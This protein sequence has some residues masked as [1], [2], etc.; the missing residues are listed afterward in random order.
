M[1]SNSTKKLN[2]LALMELVTRKLRNQ[3]S[4]NKL[5]SKNYK[6]EQ[7]IKLIAK[8]HLKNN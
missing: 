6:I 3:E 8:A 4:I 7:E 5:R 2:K 1:K